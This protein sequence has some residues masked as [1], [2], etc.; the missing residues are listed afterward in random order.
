MLNRWQHEYLS[1]LRERYRSKASDNKVKMGQVV[2][3]YDNLT[4]RVSWK[5][6]IITKLFPGSDG[7]VRSVE[8]RTKSGF[9]LRPITKLFPLEVECVEES[10]TPLVPGPEVIS[11]RRPPQRQAAIAAREKFGGV[12]L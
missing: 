3:I 8:V 5:M 11:D 1:C 4:P 2:L 12:A 10:F 7:Y 9:L 6:G